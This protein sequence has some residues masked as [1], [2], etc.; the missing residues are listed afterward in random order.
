MTD[1][2]HWTTTTGAAVTEQDPGPEL[3]LTFQED[4][5][6]AVVSTIHIRTTVADILG[7]LQLHGVVIGIS[8]RRIRQAVRTARRS[9]RP[10]HDVVVAVGQHPRAAARQHLTFHL[11]AGLDEPPSLDP[12]HDVLVLSW[13]QVREQAPDLRA[14]V[15]AAGDRLASI[16]S[17]PGTEG[18]DVKGQAIPVP[19]SPE[20]LPEDLELVPGTGVALGPT[21]VEFV[22]LSYGYA[23]WHQ[24][25]LCVLEPLWID[26]DMMQACFL[27]VRAR[28]SGKRPSA[29]DLRSLLDSS[30]VSFGVDEEAIQRL[31]GD[32]I[33][34]PLTAIAVGELPRPASQYTP[35][36]AQE[37]ELKHGS[38]RDDGSIDFHE[39]NIFPPVRDGDLLAE[40]G[41]RLKGT[42]GHTIFG[43]EIDPIGE[44][45][46]IEFTAG[47]NVRM[48]TD[49]D[50]QRLAATCDGG[51]V[52]RSTVTQ[53]AS[54]AIACRQY[55]MAVHP[56]AHIESD[57]GLETGNVDFRGHVVI[58]GSV[59][60]GFQVRATG[61]IA[62]AGSVE[63]G[64]ELRAGGDINIQQGI[65]GR[66]TRIVTEGALRAKFV[67]EAR[68]KA[69]G[70]VS[71]GSYI[72]S[73]HIQ[74]ASRVEVE[75]LAGPDNTGGIVGGEIWAQGG[76][77]TRNAG[78]A[79]SNSTHLF[80]G[81]S[82]VDLNSL[83]Q[84]RQDIVRVETDLV[85]RLR[86]IGLPELTAP[87]VREL[88]AQYP[89]RRD[90]ILNSVKVARDL[91]K[92]L[93]QQ[94]TDEQNLKNRVALLAGAT[95]ISVPG[96]A[97]CDVTLQIGDRQLVLPQDQVAVCFRIDPTTPD[98]VVES[99]D[100]DADT[101]ADE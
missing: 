93:A 72:H 75:G 36:F 74:C 64:S 2:V 67:Q 68:V 35:A 12:I 96:R 66:Q 56:V 100:A 53:G 101:D 89:G 54:G 70:N 14:W 8:E 39:R 55:Y 50:V 97:F 60:S 25:Q 31:S 38:F 6:R 13:D 28:G 45:I 71:I 84:V 95:S 7:L 99:L 33:H 19:S 62:V 44:A 47:E 91:E 92:G 11:Q 51:V 4:G 15:V 49:D 3:Q 77:T 88:V 76:I 73:A 20:G 46:D 26:A 59:T 82:P 21:G 57:V 78:S 83:E 5:V 90:E 29:T 52:L 43:I 22:A 98:L 30:G 34:E 69:G 23:G 63:A 1:S 61:G 10:I 32:T 94:I 87:A 58:D 17:L 24:G 16:E 81:I 27:H 80:A 65:V 40:E 41:F 42:P 86:S 79:R 48:S 85:R 37:W 9:N 18:L